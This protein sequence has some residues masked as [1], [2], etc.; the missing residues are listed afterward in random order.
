MAKKIT[1]CPICF[2]GGVK[3]VHKGTRDNSE[4]DVYRCP[5]CGTRFL[6]VVNEDYDYENGFMYETNNMSDL[7][8]ETRLHLFEGDD[9]RRFEMVKLLCENRNVLDFGCGFG[10]FLQRI[11]NVTSECCG[12]ELGRNERDYLTGKGI[13]CFKT[14][15]EADRK[16]DIITL[17][18]TFEHLSNPRMWLEKFCSYLEPGGKLII[19]VPNADD[20]LL[21]VY[22]SEEFAD[23]TYWSAHLF[24]YTV[25]SLSMIVEQSGKYDILSAGQLQRYTIAN[26]LMWLAK[27]LPGGHDKW[28]NLDSKKLNEAYAD[29][30]KEL[31]MSDTLFFVLQR[32]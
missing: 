15:E 10:G 2:G 13:T 19:E 9:Q 5:E 27:G 26:H 17:F 29:K 28:S 18:H 25:K 7:D 30:L 16:F 22:E 11:S 4:I 21:S 3:I 6:S 12:V 23:F 1:Q 31:Q 24:L 32:K 8:I 20:I 14:I